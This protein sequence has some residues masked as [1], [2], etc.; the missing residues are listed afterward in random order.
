[1]K[2]NFLAIATLALVA[3]GCS[4]NEETPKQG[5]FPADKVIRVVPSVDAIT[6]AGNTDANL[7]E[8]ALF[9]DNATDAAYSYAVHMQ[10]EGDAFVSYTNT[11]EDKKR[12]T[13]LWEDRITPVKVVAFAPYYG[14]GM[15]LSM[16]IETGVYPDQSTASK[17][18]LSDFCYFNNLTFN[19]ETDLNENGAIPIILKH[20]NAKL[21]VTVALG[22]EFNAAAGQTPVSPISSMEVEGTIEV[23]QYN[24]TDGSMVLGTSKQNIKMFNE[25]Y[26][27]GV[28]VTTSGKAVYECVLVPQTVA[29]GTFKVSMMIGDVKYTYTV[30]GAVTLT[31]DTKYTL[32]LNVGKDQVAAGEMTFTP[33]TENNGGY[34]TTD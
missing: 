2:I 13:M 17:V 18:Q 21:I 8:F 30:P 16:I 6:R 11:K 10:K 33:W 32:A 3:V 1:M 22:S 24:L 9:I 15:D 25:S 5:N 31:R 34:Y 20:M 19:P 14:D 27:A 12:L 26:T 7:T 23:G 28:G 29:A 4:K